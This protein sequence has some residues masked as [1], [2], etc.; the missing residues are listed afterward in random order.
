MYLRFK[1][2]NRRIV[3]YSRKVIAVLGVNSN[4]KDGLHLPMLEFDDISF[5]DLLTELRELQEVFRLGEII[6]VSTGRADSYHAIVC[7]S[8]Q[9]QEA[10]RVVAYSKYADLK[11]LQFSLKREHFTLRLSPK[12]SRAIEL[13]DILP[14]RYESK[15]KISDLEGFVIYET[16]VRI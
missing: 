15:A 12:G 9:W 14:S 5:R 1:I 6:I 8:L 2:L 7:S 13:V 4:T 10:V 16:A 11:H 3:F